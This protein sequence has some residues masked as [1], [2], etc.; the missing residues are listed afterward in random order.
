MSRYLA[1]SFPL[2]G[3][4]PWGIYDK[5]TLIAR[6]G[7][8]ALALRIVAALNAREPEPER[9]APSRTPAAPAA[10]SSSRRSGA[11]HES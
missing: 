10:G 9:K 8:E 7:S 4:F 1:S 3:A 11:W 6:A 5:G 2:P